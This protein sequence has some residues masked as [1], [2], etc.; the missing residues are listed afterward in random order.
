MNDES[1]HS[2]HDN[3]SSRYLLAGI[4]TTGAVILAPYVLPAIGIGS[5]TSTDNLLGICSRA[6]SGLASIIH[7]GIQSIPS[8]GANL[9]Q[10]GWQSSLAL[11]AIGV[12]GVLL[13][14]YLEKHYDKK[15]HIPWGK[16]IKYTA[17]ATTILIALPS[18]LSGLSIGI[19]FLASLANNPG[20]SK[21][22]LDFAQ[23]TFGMISNAGLPSVGAGIAG[24]IPHLL[25]CGAALL[26]TAGAIF[27]SNRSSHESQKPSAAVEQPN[28]LS[29][30]TPLQ[31]GFRSAAA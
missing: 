11:G 5:Y 3:S 25:T 28:Y 17:L 1:P 2:H 4:A 19:S 30:L 20:F 24:L 14:N 18:I 21:G 8:L 9:L 29:R 16:I 23:S 7:D 15:G 22:V 6:S 13:G 31:V 10:A 12:G 27:L 26:P